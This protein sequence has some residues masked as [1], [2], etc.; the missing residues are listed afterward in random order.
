M[1]K[2]EKGEREKLPLCSIR[3]AAGEGEIMPRGEF[4]SFKL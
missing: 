4:L 3:H 2:T 1:W